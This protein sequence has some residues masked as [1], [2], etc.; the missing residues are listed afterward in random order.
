MRIARIVE[1]DCI[2]CTKCLKVC[3]VDAIVGAAWQIRPPS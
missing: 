3:P 2:G 1:V